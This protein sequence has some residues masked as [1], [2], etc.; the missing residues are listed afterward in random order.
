VSWALKMLGFTT[1]RDGLFQL[2]E[3]QLVSV[4]HKESILDVYDVDKTPL[5]RYE[6]DLLPSP[7]SYLRWK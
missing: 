7:I 4:V 3:E 2:S 5:G 6:S 1:S